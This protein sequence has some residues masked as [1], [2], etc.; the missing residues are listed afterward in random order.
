M[1][2]KAYIYVQF[3]ARQTFLSRSHFTYHETRSFVKQ[4]I[5]W[6]G[7]V[8]LIGSI[9]CLMFGLELG[10]KEYAWDSS[11]IIGLFVGFIVLLIVFLVQTFITV[12]RYMTRLAAYYQARVDAL[13]LGAAHDLS[14]AD[15]QKLTAVLS[16]ETYDFGKPP[17][18]PTEQA[19][20]LARSIMA[21]YKK[22]E[23]SD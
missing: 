15:L 11:Q 19:V 12:F 16:P 6:L 10:G 18:T 8:L 9:V 21:A 17:R 1:P 13:L 20:D 14:I 5:D 2:N 3:G 22:R 23:D 4:K 7:T